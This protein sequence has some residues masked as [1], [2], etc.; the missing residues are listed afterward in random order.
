MDTTTL[1]AGDA[2]VTVAPS[3]GCRLASLRVRGHELLSDGA[4]PSQDDGLGANIFGWGSFVMAPWAGRIRHG[5][6]RWGGRELQLDV[7][8]DVHALH[9]LVFDAPWTAAD[10][11][12]GSAAWQV[13]VPAAAWFAPLRITQHVMLTEAA[14]RLHL[15]VQAPEEPAPVT[16]GWHPWFR[17]EVGGAALEFDLPDRRMLVRDQEGIATAE[18]IAAPTG[19][20]D[21]AFVDL[22]GPVVLRWPGLVELTMVSDGPVTVVFTEPS[23][24]VCIEPQSGPPDEVNLPSPRVAAPGAPLHLS[25][26]WSWTV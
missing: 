12:T 3:D 18:R 7:R 25:S 9:G 19:P 17:R 23:T 13:E 8:D 24:V 22:A 21:D 26:T 16:V 14:L 1:T 5:R 4:A 11:T 2:S 20:V 10:A 15:E 6:A